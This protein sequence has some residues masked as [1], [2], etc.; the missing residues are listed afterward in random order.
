MT[1]DAR[2]QMRAARCT[3]SFSEDRE[4]VLAEE[5]EPEADSRLGLPLLGRPSFRSGV[6]GESRLGLALLAGPH[7]APERS[8]PRARS[9]Y[10]RCRELQE[11]LTP[12]FQ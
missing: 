12:V 10:R 8:V 6:R 11:P 3:L 1:S 7:S 5:A 9:S 2:D 4:R